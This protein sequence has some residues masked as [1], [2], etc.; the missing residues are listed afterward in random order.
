MINNHAKNGQV[1]KYRQYKWLCLMVLM[2]SVASADIII[3]SAPKLTASSYILM[4]ANTGKVLAELDSNKRLPPAS[5]TKM[6]TIYAA[7]YELARGNFT[8]DDPVRISAN[9]RA[10]KGSRM[11]LEEGSMV[12]LEE[13][14]RGVIVQ[15][16]NDA[17]VAVSE[18]IAGDEG[19][20]TDLMNQHAE[21]LGL[22]NTHF[23]NVTGWPAEGHYSAAADL[24]RIAVNLIRDF[25]ET[26]QMYSEKYYEYNGIR[27]PNRNALLW[28]D[29]TVDGVKTGHTDEAGYCL[30]ASAEREGMRLVSVIMGT[31]SERARASDSQR[32]LAYGFRYFETITIYKANES[33]LKVKV[34]GGANDSVSL[35]VKEDLL[36]TVPKGGRE[37]LKVST[38]VN[39]VV[40]AP[41]LMNTQMGS[42]SVKMK[43]EILFENDLISVEEVAEG[44]FLSRSWD[45]IRL[46]FIELFGVDAIKV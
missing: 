5:L 44:G 33:L 12:R 19:I 32:L 25:P 6:M 8:L 23:K 46:F 14:F 26:Y 39:G 37:D 31:K 10:M 13:L 27:Q 21:R 22:E 20:F 2:S 15:S 3:P 16:G 18:H 45:S 35:G 9:A 36:L 17:S 30:V 1:G 11:F 38:S 28:R 34:W 41:V 29:E 42:I 40:H 24:A 4:D 7:A 43:D